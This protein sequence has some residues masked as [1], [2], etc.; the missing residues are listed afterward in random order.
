MTTTVIRSYMLEGDI[1]PSKWVSSFN[2]DD[3]DAH[4]YAEDPPHSRET[5]LMKC[6]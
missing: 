1:P 2:D 6:V 4:L 3:D 5:F